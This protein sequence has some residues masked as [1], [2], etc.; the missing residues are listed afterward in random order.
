MGDF[1]G[2]PG[3]RLVWGDLRAQHSKGGK[4]LGAGL[5]QQGSRPR[6]AQEVPV[7]VCRG[8]GEATRTG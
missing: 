3:G 4:R 5:L 6:Q 8:V 2:G 7:G 1:I